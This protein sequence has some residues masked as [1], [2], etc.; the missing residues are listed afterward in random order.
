LATRRY[1]IAKGQREQ[2]IVEAAGAATATSS[3]EFTFD[4]AVSP[5][6]TRQ[7]VL[8]GLEKIMDYIITNKFPPA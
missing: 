4:L 1:S 6:L 8:D 5:A 7:D 2:D 3:M